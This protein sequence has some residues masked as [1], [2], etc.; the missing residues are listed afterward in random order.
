ME[1]FSDNQKIA[2]QL[3]EHSNR[4]KNEQLT[5]VSR[6]ELTKDEYDAKKGVSCEEAKKW[7]GQINDLKEDISFGETEAAKI[8]VKIKE[9]RKTLAKAEEIN[10]K[11][12]DDWTADEVQFFDE[13][14]PSEL[15]K[16]LRD[17]DKE[18]LEIYNQKSVRSKLI[19]ELKAKIGELDE[20]QGNAKLQR[21]AQPG[22]GYRYYELQDG[23]DALPQPSELSLV[24][25]GRTFRN[26]ITSAAYQRTFHK[27]NLLQLLSKYAA[28][29]GPEYVEKRTIENIKN[30]IIKH[31]D[32]PR[33]M[34]LES[35]T[36]IMTH[37]VRLDFEAAL[38]IN[39]ENAQFKKMLIN[40]ADGS[41][42]QK[43]QKQNK[44]QNHFGDS[45]YHKKQKGSEKDDKRSAGQQDQNQQPENQKQRGGGRGRG[46]GRG[47]GRGRG[48][49]GQRGRGGYSQNTNQFN[50]G[51]KDNGGVE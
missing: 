49:G 26:T 2:K 37:E 50:G 27:D 29:M 25:M 30:K 38:H 32:L 17:L 46:Q 28:A 19:K 33:K 1:D 40:P 14:L 34:V 39:K 31:P 47:R 21:E 3:Q 9:G 43:S 8:I 48:R 11:P 51:F 41:Y 16:E 35:C 7:K 12:R 44:R 24:D 42:D 23:T 45:P 18:K 6:N 4:L 36:P 15:R 20:I 22:G 10:E 5:R 13:N